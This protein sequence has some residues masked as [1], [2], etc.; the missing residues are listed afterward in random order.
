MTSKGR[1]LAG[2]TLLK[3]AVSAEHKGVVVHDVLE[4]RLVENSGE[5]LLGQSHTHSVGKALSKRSSG[6]LHSSSDHVLGVAGGERPQLAE[7]LQVFNTEVVSGQMKHG[8]QKSTR[9]T[10]GKDKAVAVGPVGVLGREVHDFREQDVS[11]GSTT[12]RSAWVTRVGLFNHVRR[13][14]T[15]R[16]NASSIERHDGVI[17]YCNFNKPIERDCGRT[18]RLCRAVLVKKRCFWS[19]SVC[20]KP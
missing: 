17:N 14:N 7:L 11:D 2:D 10:I 5:V 12:H 6:N 4:A 1:S 20:V 13:Q 15:D 16:V 18:L 8:I 9:V 3:A 19:V